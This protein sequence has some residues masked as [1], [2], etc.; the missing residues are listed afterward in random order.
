MKVI[1]NVP[2]FYREVV[3]AYNKCKLQN[4]L[5]SPGDILMQ[6]LW[7]NINLT[8]N[9]K[10][11]Y[12]KQWS[13][14]NIFYIK[15]VVNCDGSFLTEYQI[16]QKLQETRNWIA[17]YFQVKKCVEKFLSK[18]NRILY[19]NVVVRTN[20]YMTTKEAKV[21]IVNQKSKFFYELLVNKE[22]VIPNHLA[23]MFLF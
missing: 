20:Y 22:M 1:V 18:F 3:T 10:C 14:Q 17:E 19:T 21:N 15:D 5:S 16:K 8:I 6:P 2:I 13:C 9:R 23:R 12:F 4:T 7:G 11:L